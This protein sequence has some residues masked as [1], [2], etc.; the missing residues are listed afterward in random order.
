[1]NADQ[2]L[3][4]Y[5]QV[6][7]APD[8]ITHLRRFILDLAVRGK[9][10]PQD[11]NDEPASK[12]L[13]RIATEKVRLMKTVRRKKN[14]SESNRRLA[15]PFRLP[16][17]WIWAVIGDIFWYDAGIKRK[18]ESLNQD[19]WLLELEDIEKNTGRLLIRVKVSNRESSSTKSEFCIGDILYGKLRPYL[20]KVIVAD[21]PGYS[22]TE[23]V[24]LRPYLPICS[25]YCSL[26]LRRPDF[27]TYVERLGQGT[28]MPRLRTEDAI[29][30]PFPLPPLAEQH[31]IVAKVNELMALCDQLDVEREKRETTRDRLAVAS[32]ARLNTSD[33]ATFREHA[34]FALDNL[35][36]FTTRSDQIQALRQ[37]ILDLAVRGKL[38]P[39][40]PNDEPASELL[41]RIA[42]KKAQLV[43][44]KKIKKTKPQLLI[45]FDAHV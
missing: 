15:A 5:E 9:L 45:S 28:K 6:A 33:S 43:K 40:D 31:R 38:V 3:T 32:L 23:I 12:L 11:P 39:Q 17:S 36:S 16:L 24:A 10:V 19:L 1:M 2:L 44:A 29:I 34:T 4:H 20:N 37:T 14:K 7:D 25:Q 22:T 18:A 8:A 35:Y 42:V 26:A 21:E 27:V 41:K 13:K 30:A